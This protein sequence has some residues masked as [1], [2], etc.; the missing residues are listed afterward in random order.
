MAIRIEMPSDN[1]D[2]SHR[3]PEDIEGRITRRR[4]HDEDVDERDAWGLT[5]HVG[6]CSILPVVSVNWFLSCSNVSTALTLESL[7]ELSYRI[8]KLFT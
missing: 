8:P 1:D 2:S 5:E 6:S 7:F 4:S 3:I